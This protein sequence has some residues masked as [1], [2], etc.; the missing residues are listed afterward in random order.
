MI[1]SDVMAGSASEAAEGIVQLAKQVQVLR[2]QAV[3]DG[4][5]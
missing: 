5:I 4:G 2:L 1:T 3:R